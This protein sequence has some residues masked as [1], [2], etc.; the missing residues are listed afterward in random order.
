MSARSRVEKT[1]ITEGTTAAADD[2]AVTAGAVMTLVPDTVSRLPP[3][4]TKSV[5]K[6]AACSAVLRVLAPV[7]AMVWDVV[8]T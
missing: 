3:F 7:A 8:A 2:A 6:V 1:T 5:W 4:A